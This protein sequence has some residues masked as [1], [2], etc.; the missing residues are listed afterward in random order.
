MSAPAASTSPGPV[1]MPEETVDI[2]PAFN[3]WRRALSAITGLG[4]S[5]D[6]VALQSQAK[7]EEKR[8]KDCQR[9]EA[10]RDQ[11]IGESAIISN[12]H[13]QAGLFD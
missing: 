10:W 12:D 9:C 1:T 5:Q 6:T 11:V 8:L 7:A 4:A 13:L 3:A 2:M